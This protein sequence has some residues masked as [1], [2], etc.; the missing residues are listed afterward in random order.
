[1]RIA[2]YRVTLLLTVALLACVGSVGYWVRSRI[3]AVSGDL[4]SEHFLQPVYFGPPRVFV[5]TPEFQLRP[6]FEKNRRDIAAVSDLAFLTAQKGQW[7][8]A[9]MFYQ[10][11]L[12]IRPTD[13]NAI[14]GRVFALVNLNKPREAIEF[15]RKTRAAL[16]AHEDVAFTW[17][18]EGDIWWFLAMSADEGSRKIYLESAEKC[19]KRALEIV[20]NSSRFLLGMVRV[21]LA[22]ND[23]HM[24]SILVER[25]YTVGCET[26][27]EQ[28]LASYYRGTILE[29]TGEL[30]KAQSYYLAAISADPESFVDIRKVKK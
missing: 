7:Q 6:R 25:V 19:Q 9:Q 28:A 23:L 12:R 5:S 18:V 22:K 20:P 21:A 24:A 27:R 15:L 11:W 2:R 13:I 30:K 29:R 1:M 4:L 10:E 3:S 26:N 8:D 16:K 14:V 17:H